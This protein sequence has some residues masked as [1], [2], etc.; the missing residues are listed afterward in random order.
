LLLDR[1]NK[2]GKEKICLDRFN[3][4]NQMVLSGTSVKEISS[5]FGVSNAYVHQILRKYGASPHL[6]RCIRTKNRIEKV[7]KL[8]ESGETI[9]NICADTGVTETTIYRDLKN[10]G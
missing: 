8:R 6:L 7:A 2:Y 3:K 5:Q 9:K 4:W 1:R 10:A